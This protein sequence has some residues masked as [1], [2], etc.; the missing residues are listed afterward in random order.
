M[1][2]CELTEERQR[3]ILA[4][5]R[6]GLPQRAALGSAGYHRSALQ[7]W[8]ARAL[9]GAE[10]YASFIEQMEIA[11]MEAEG[12]LTRIVRTGADEDPNHAKWLLERRFKWWN[13]RDGQPTEVATA[14]PE[15]PA[16][17]TDADIEASL[18]G[19]K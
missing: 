8:R 3:I 4:C 14:A 6:D 10:P 19:G 5:L 7:H 13:P 15:L 9:E 11:E 2:T 17:A 18:Q 16:G 12:A 1:R